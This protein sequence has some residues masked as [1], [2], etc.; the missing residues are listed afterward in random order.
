[1][2]ISQ[3]KYVHKILNKFDLGSVR[4]VTTPYEA[5]KPK[6]KNESDSPVN[7]HLYRSM[8]G[9]LMYLTASRPDI[10][11]AVSACLRNQ[12][13]STTSNLEAVKKIF[14]YLKGQLKLSMYV[15]PAGRVV[16]PT[17]G[18]VVPVG[19]VIIVS[20]GSD[21]ESDDASIH[22]EATNA[23]QQPNIQPQIIT[24]VSNNNA[25]FPYLKKDEYE[26]EKT[27]RDRDGRVIIL[28]PTTT[29]EH[30]AA[31]R[32]SKARTTLLL[33]IPDDHVALTLKIKG[34][35]ELL[36]FDDLYYKLKTL[37]VD[38]KGYTTFSSSQSIVQAILHSLVPTVLA[39]RCHMKIVQVILQ[40]LPTLLHQTLRM[41][42]NDL[43]E[44]LD[45]KEM[46]LKWK[47]AMLS[48]RVHK[49]EQK[50]G[51]KIDFDKKESVRAK[52]GND[53][54][55]Y[56]SFKIKEIGK[57]EEDSK[58]LI[59]VDTLVDL[60]YPDGESDGVIASKEFGMIDGYD[61]MDVIEEGAA[62]IYN[63][64]TRA[65]SEEANT[66]GDAGEFAL[67]GVTSEENPFP[68][69]EDEGVFDSG[70]SRS[71]TAQ[72]ESELASCIP[73]GVVVASC[74]PAN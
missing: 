24:T 10:M 1:M 56:S 19:I 35:L 4:T 25:K 18:Y 59:T 34:G 66:V 40:I 63:L 58:A 23:Q 64:I 72:F 13:T 73:S 22:S 11:F 31:Q 39:K 12:V 57:K 44:K 3:D 20:P 27:G 6:S 30:I 60:T 26:L 61:T 14:K 21:N 16:A 8:I 38:V 68:D 2:F 43:I 65:D 7:V 51:R 5:L 37:E 47:M 9:S 67:M 62:K 15:V 71:M 54:Q 49:F 53:K 48:L 50:A 36:S 69:A 33:S 28:P 32:E 74:V 29:D 41:D 52:E 70:C 42:L 45:L 17:G 46:D 55:R